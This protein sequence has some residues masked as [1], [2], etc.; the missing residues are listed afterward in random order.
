MKVSTLPINQRQEDLSPEKINPIGLTETSNVSETLSLT[1]I[2]SLFSTRNKDTRTADNREMNKSII[3]FCTMY[4]FRLRI[5]SNEMDYCSA[6][7]F[8]TTHFFTAT[9]APALPLTNSRK[10]YAPP[11]S[12]DAT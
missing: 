9:Y 2:S 5:L 11:A 6:V 7:H 12:L 10:K 8:T 1:I 3:T 4:N